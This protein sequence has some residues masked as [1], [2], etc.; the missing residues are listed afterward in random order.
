VNV[1]AVA[2][3]TRLLLPA[4]RAARGRVILIN[5]MAAMRVVRDRGA[6]TASKLALGALADALQA[7]ELHNGVGVTSIYPGRT[8]T[9]MQQKVRVHEGGAFQP[10]EYLAP[11]AVAHAVLAAVQAPVDSQ[12]TGIVVTP[13]IVR[14]LN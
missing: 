13:A 6:Y 4:L 5:S 7:E 9:D 14:T 8:T 3:L 2:E 12:L 10:E 1:F 11:E